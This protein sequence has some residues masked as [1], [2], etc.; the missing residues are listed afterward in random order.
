MSAPHVW[1]LVQRWMDGQ[2]IRVN[3]SQLADALGVGRQTITQWKRGETRPS[4]ANL[5]RLHEV[6]RIPY[7]D[8]T[9]ALLRD[10]GY[11]DAREDV[12]NDERSASTSQAG[13]RLAESVSDSHNVSEFPS[14]EALDPTVPDT[15][16]ARSQKGKGKAQAERERQDEE[17][18]SHEQRT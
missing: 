14:P 4:P 5:R 7:S 13:L 18:E 10:M 2:V 1:Q 6:T 8:L 15:A 17:G 3:Q 12:G 16:A 11:V 9:A